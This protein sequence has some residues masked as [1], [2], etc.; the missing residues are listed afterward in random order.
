MASMTTAIAPHHAVT[1]LGI[2]RR[3]PVA[4][5]FVAAYLLLHPRGIRADDRQHSGRVLPRHVGRRVRAHLDLQPQGG[6]VLLVTLWHASFNLVTAT[7]AGRGTVA[8]LVS[9]NVMV[10]G[11]ALAAADIRA[12]RKG[13]PSVL[14]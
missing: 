8:A 10:F 13:A 5:Y 3:H 2:V 4:T 14:G 7:R 12:R 11:S 9:I 1:V 6:S